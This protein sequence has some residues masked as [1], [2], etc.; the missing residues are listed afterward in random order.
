[1]SAHTHH[2][3]LDSPDTP[4]AIKKA[5][6]T[7]GGFPYEVK[8]EKKV[9]EEELY[10][11][12]LQ[13]IALQEHMKRQGDRIIILF[14]GRDAAGKSS[15]INAYREHLNPRT[16]LS[17]A[18]PAPSDRE[19]GQWYFQRYVD[20]LPSAGETVLFDRSWYNRSGVEA[21]MGFADEPAVS[22]F[23]EEAP[24]FESMLVRDGI[25]LF[26][27]WLS[28]GREMQMLR[29]WE[30]RHDPLKQ[31]KLSP[32]D[33]KAM[34]QWDDY[35]KAG[36]RTLRATDTADAP[37]TVILANDQRRARLNT[38]R[39]VLHRIDYAGK[40]EGQ[41]GAIDDKI[42]LGAEEFLA[43]RGV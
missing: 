8:L 29:F 38:I 9:Y 16:T 42:V 15:S 6:L 22:A 12:H 24:R 21:V 23:L 27:F 35:T 20:F 18:L 5:S 30:R 37:W 10:A 39:T 3:D 34:T 7:S 13:L 43:E 32:I 19:R 26:K 17:A 11:L 2:F 25:R 4:T 40:D 31:W 41:I 14:E 1:M 33:L 28:I 36:E